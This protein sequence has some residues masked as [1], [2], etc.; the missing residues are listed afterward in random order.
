MSDHE[1]TAD[2]VAEPDPTPGA[3][4]APRRPRRVLTVVALTVAVVVAGSYVATELMDIPAPHT[5]V[6]L[7]STPPSRRGDVFPARTVAAPARAVPL[8]VREQP[9]PADVPWKGGRITVGEFLATTH[10]Q[11]FLVVRDGHLTHE[12]YGDGVGPTTRLSSWSAAKSM[13][14]LLVGQAID[15][16]K[17]HE[18]DRLV[19]ILPELKTGGAYDSI[20][21]RNLLDMTSGVDVPESYN[22]YFPFTG[23]AR[24]YLTRDLSDFARDHRDLE[25]APGSRGSY[26][27]VDT[28]LL[29]QILTTVEGRPLADLL[30]DNIWQPMGAEHDATWNL[31]HDGG[32]EKAFCCV[33]ATARDYARLGRLVLDG[34]RAQGEQVVPT[35]WIA[36]IAAVAPHQV[37]GW[38]YS[39][40]WWHP[41]GGE[42]YSAIGIHG[43]YVYIDPA[44]KTV[45]VK[46]SDH[47]DEQDE[48]ETIEVFRAIA[49]AG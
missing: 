22:A 26:R 10:T 19:D 40:Q 11:A 12:W 7:Q 48:K 30:T 25:F 4:S 14:S 16:G 24:L 27:S 49:R 37:D 41:S 45:I 21:V 2:S 33:N 20:T 34:G 17:L 8:P 18:E 38:G 15:S 43:Q 13:V 42:D 9:L 39:A 46:L 6:E 5:L 47:G 1:Q 36:R 3:R 32:A 35:A 31:D 44:A 28:E 29:G 23:T